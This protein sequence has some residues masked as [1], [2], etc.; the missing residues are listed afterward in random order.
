[1]LSFCLSS[2]IHV[3]IVEV[4][5]TLDGT[6][7]MNDSFITQVEEREGNVEIPFY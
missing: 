5:V 6:S 7:V 3:V 4:S 2:L 1:M